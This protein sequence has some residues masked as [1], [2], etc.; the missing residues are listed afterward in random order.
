MTQTHNVT[1]LRQFL[2]VKKTHNVL[3]GSLMPSTFYQ[4]FFKKY[5]EQTLS[6]VKYL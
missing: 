4:L 1:V 3:I 2:Y 6:I 5:A